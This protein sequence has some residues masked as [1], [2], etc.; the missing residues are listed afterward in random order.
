[1]I[2]LGV[3]KHLIAQYEDNGFGDG[4]IVYC[5]IWDDADPAPRSGAKPLRDLHLFSTPEKLFELIPGARGD[6]R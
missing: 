3:L 4:S 5:R 6:C 1:M 2:T